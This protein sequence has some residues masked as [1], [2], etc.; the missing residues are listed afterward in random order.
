MVQTFS[1][2]FLGP[3]RLGDSKGAVHKKIPGIQTGNEKKTRKKDGFFWFF[4]VGHFHKGWKKIM[5]QLM[6]WACCFGVV[7]LEGYLGSTYE[8]DNQLTIS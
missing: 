4:L 1:R 6:V 8:R 7:G 3:V 2:N 5:V